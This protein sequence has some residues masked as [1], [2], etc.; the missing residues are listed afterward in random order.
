MLCATVQGNHLNSLSDSSGRHCIRSVQLCRTT[1]QIACLQQLTD[2]SSQPLVWQGRLCQCKC[3]SF[4]G[5]L[6]T[7][8]PQAWSLQQMRCCS[9][10][11]CTAHWK[12]SPACSM[13]VKPLPRLWAMSGNHL[14]SNAFVL[15]YHN[16]PRLGRI[17]L[18]A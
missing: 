2:T 7:C 5:C 13:Q 15:L 1:V 17:P 9:W 14:L 4:V 16:L 18:Y 12:W 10:T 3:G 11:A 6:Q 8:K